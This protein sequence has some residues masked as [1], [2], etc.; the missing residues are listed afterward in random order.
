M[1]KAMVPVMLLSLVTMLACSGCVVDSQVKFPSTTI[2]EKLNDNWE[3]ADAQ[4]AGLNADS[5]DRIYQEI[6]SEDRYYNALG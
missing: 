2:P 1:K 4:S 6:T 3:I 5:L